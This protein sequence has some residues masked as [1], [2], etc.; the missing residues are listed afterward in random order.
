MIVDDESRDAITEMINIGV[1]KAAGL[2]NDITGSHIQLRVPEI[3]L[4]PI[5]EIANV[6]KTVFGADILSTVIQEFQGNFS[7]VTALVFPPDS[8]L[9]LV[10]LLSGDQS[11][12][13]NMDA[14]Q[15]ETL[16]EVGNIIINAVMGSISNVLSEH[17]AFSL[18]VYY[19]GRLFS[20]AANYIDGE[21]NPW[22]IIAR[23]QFLIEAMQIEG[24]ILL[25][26]EVGS[27]E[28][29]MKSVQKMNG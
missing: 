16:K 20:I 13:T 23:T 27:M 28:Q 3:Q 29:L 17:F 6:N 4:V 21:G 7:G 5:G 1:G 26:L 2:L 24:T 10:N 14:V 15:V 22:I 19:E 25:V 12:A 9:S 18:P 8:A 11:P